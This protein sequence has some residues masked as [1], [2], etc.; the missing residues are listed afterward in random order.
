MT[1][2]RVSSADC[3]VCGVSRVRPKAGRRVV[4]ERGRARGVAKVMGSVNWRSAIAS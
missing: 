3:G 2:S 1:R 4:V